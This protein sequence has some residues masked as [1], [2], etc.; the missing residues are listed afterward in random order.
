MKMRRLTLR[1]RRALQASQPLRL[2]Q[3]AP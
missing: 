1:L 2:P 3:A